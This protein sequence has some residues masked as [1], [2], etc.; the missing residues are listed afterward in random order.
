DASRQAALHEL[1]RRVG[2]DVEL[3]HATARSLR[4]G[5]LRLAPRAGH[6]VA[7]RS[8]PTDHAPP[9]PA[10][11]EFFPL[12]QPRCLLAEPGPVV[13][14][15]MSANRQA[16]WGPSDPRCLQL[17]QE[18]AVPT[19]LVAERSVQILPTEARTL[20]CDWH[21]VAAGVFELVG[22]GSKPIALAISQPYMVD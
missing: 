20:R 11:A 13:L 12:E 15:V 14:M 18:L 17:L 7:L 21:A 22:S 1:N 19:Q 2:G 16:W 6:L 10:M 8:K 3:A 4:L 5:L 9:M